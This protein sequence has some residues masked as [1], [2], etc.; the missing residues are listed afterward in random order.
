MKGEEGINT[1]RSKVKY[2]RLTDFTVI[3]I[4]EN[5]NRTYQTNDGVVEK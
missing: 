4:N 3:L 1:V 2:I 5:N